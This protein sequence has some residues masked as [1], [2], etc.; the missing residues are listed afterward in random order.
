MKKTGIAAALLG[1]PQILILDEHLHCA[2]PFVADSTQ[3]NP[4]RTAGN[5]KYNH[6]HLQSR[7]S[8]TSL[9]CAAPV[10]LEKGK[11]VRDIATSD[12]TLKELE[13]YFAV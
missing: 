9:R 3:T 6:A 8:I 1:D 11:V 13:S 7:S 12:D 4:Q 2:R 5:E 10:V